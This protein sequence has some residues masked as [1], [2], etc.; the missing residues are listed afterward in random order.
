MTLLLEHRKIRL[1]IIY[2]MYAW[3]SAF[4]TPGLKALSVG[5]A[6]VYVRGEGVFRCMFLVIHIAESLAKVQ[7]DECYF[8]SRP[9]PLKILLFSA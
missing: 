7:G 2:I 6:P 4:T 5:S 1:D 9:F 3:A 8:L